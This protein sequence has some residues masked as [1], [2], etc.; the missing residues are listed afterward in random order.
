MVAVQLPNNQTKYFKYGYNSSTD[1]PVYHTRQTALSGDVEADFINIS[2]HSDGGAVYNDE[3]V[4]DGIHGDF[5]GNLLQKDSEYGYPRS[6]IFNKNK[7]GS[8]SGNFIGNSVF[9]ATNFSSGNDIIY[10]EYAAT[11]KNI[12]GS[13]IANYGRVINN[14]GTIENIN[15]DFIGNTG[16]VIYNSRT[17]GN[18]KGNFIANS[19]QDDTGHAYGGA[20]NFESGGGNK[21]GNIT[22]NFINNYVLSKNNWG[23]AVGGAISTYNQDT[24]TNITGN[25]IGNY[26][27]SQRYAVGGA[28]RG[29]FATIS[30]NF[31]NNYAISANAFAYGGAILSD[32]NL[33]WDHTLISPLTIASL[34]DTVF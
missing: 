7:I 15:A 16:G 9:S 2:S 14:N 8:I 28:I 17:M 13:F 25:F 18:I 4:I 29:S 20:M 1:R 11:I 6:I 31:L 19:V 23:N 33:N 10:N 26:A 3:N 32:G 24:P 22:A 30:G 12:T 34:G 21:T 27:S 5:I